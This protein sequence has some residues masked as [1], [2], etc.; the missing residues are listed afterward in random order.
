M[1][2][3]QPNGHTPGDGGA[4]QL[5]VWAVGVIA[6]ALPSG[7]VDTNAFMKAA[8]ALADARATIQEKK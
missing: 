5:D 8:S 7:A 4:R 6:D 3:F 1:V 2:G